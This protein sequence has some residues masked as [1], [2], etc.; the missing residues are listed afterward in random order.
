MPEFTPEIDAGYGNEPTETPYTNGHVIDESPL[1]SQYDSQDAHFAAV[2]RL[3]DQGVASYAD[4]S[5]IEGYSAEDYE[6][7]ELF[8]PSSLNTTP[9]PGVSVGLRERA[10]AVA[11]LMDG[12]AVRNRLDGAKRSGAL[13]KYANPDRVLEGMERDAHY[14][15]GSQARAVEVLAKTA[16]MRAVGFSD[17]EVE[18]SRS[19]VMRTLTAKH[20]TAKG[21]VSL[22]DTGKN[23]QALRNKQKTVTARTAKKVLGS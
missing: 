23:A 10:G 1:D 14:R 8:A 2:D 17:A 18:A 21:L 22:Q 20:R 11:E 6:L 4:A 13:G 7:D 5:K 15:K 12:I 9:T 3:S 16:A 19:I